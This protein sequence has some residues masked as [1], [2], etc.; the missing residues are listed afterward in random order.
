MPR[1]PSPDTVLDAPV[2]FA[3]TAE[4]PSARG[5]PAPEL[6]EVAPASPTEAASSTA[7]PVVPVAPLVALPPSAVGLRLAMTID[8]CDGRPDHPLDDALFA[9]LRDERIPAAVFVS[10]GFASEHADAVRTIAAEPLFS[11]E[12]HGWEHRPCTTD[13][14]YVFGIRATL[15][16]AGERAE[17]DREAALLEPL[18]GRRP[19]LFRSGTATYDAT[20][21]RA[22]WELGEV[23]VAFSISDIG[24]SLSRPKLRSALESADDGAIILLHGHRPGGAAA[25]ALADALPRLRERGAVFVSLRDAIDARP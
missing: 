16:E 15:D 24:A 21:I 9:L 23:P 18:A 1:A 12:N 5:A 8:L 25:E 19:R 4:N 22:A 3:T 6:G 7:V 10:G 14:R 11:V 13:G 20:C 2:A 17:I